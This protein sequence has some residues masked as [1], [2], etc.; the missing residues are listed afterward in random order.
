[1]MHQDTASGC[2]K[3]LDRASLFP[4][5]GH[6][7]AD[8]GCGAGTWLLEFMQWGADPAALCGID[9]SADRIAAARQRIPHADFA[10]RKRSRAT[11]ARR[12]L[13]LGKSV[14]SFYFDS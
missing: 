6:R 3:M 9:L 7:I 12:I 11:L 4:L 2:I 13:R 5:R 10:Y 8:I 1:M 14:H